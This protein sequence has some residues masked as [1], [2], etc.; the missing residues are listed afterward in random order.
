MGSVS[1]QDDDDFAL[2]VQAAEPRLHRALAA[3]LG[4]ERGREATAEALAYA[5][6]HWDRVVA[7]ANPVGYLYRV[8]A[9][10]VRNR[11]IRILFV[12][13]AQDEP[14]IVPELDRALL[15]LSERQRIAVVLIHAYGWTST[16]V[17]EMIG[18]KPSTVQT[19]LERGLARLRAE[20]KVEGKEH[21]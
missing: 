10:R 6:E 5:W 8:G 1:D 20:L 19:H 14:T 11:R 15:A 7:M 4:S 3:K 18:I 21:A 13:P 17:A 2:F 12:Q 16:E 9:S